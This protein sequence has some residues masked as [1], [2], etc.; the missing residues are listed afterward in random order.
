MAPLKDTNF[1]TCLSLKL[2]LFSLEKMLWVSDI[3]CRLM[4]LCSVSHYLPSSFSDLL[5]W[6]N[7]AFTGT[8][9]ATTLCVSLPGG[10]WNTAP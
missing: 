8:S 9:L 3:C 6:S 7:S 2:M 10:G 1:I 5:G 4:E